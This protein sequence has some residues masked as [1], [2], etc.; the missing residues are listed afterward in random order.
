MSGPLT[1]VSWLK[2]VKPDTA[3]TIFRRTFEVA[4][5]TP[6]HLT[7]GALGMVEVWL[8]GQL[9]TQDRYVPVMSNYTWRDP[10]GR[11]YPIAEQP[12]HYRSYY[13]DYQVML[14][15][16]VNVLALRLGNGWYHQTVR[17]VEGPMDYG[18]PQLAY[19]LNWQDAQGIA[20]RLVSDAQTLC[21]QGEIRQNNLYSGEVHDYRLQPSAWL[22]GLADL[23]NWQPAVVVPAPKTELTK[24]TCPADRVERVIHPD[25]LQTNGNDKLFDCQENITGVVRVLLTGPAGSRVTLQYA[26]ELTADHQALDFASAGGLDQV[27]QDR[28]ISAGKPVVAWAHFAWHGFRYFSVDGPATV[29]GVD[30]IH[31]EAKQE[32]H[33]SSDHAGLNWLFASYRR[34]QLNN[35]HCGVPLDCPHRERLGYTGDGQLTVASAEW[36]FDLNAFYAKWYQDICDG[37]DRQTGHIQ[38]TAPYYG[39]GGGAGGWGA[40]VY[41]VP[42]T[43][44]QHTGDVAWLKRAWQPL[45]HWL[46]YMHAH[47]QAGLVTHEEEGG[48]NLGEWCAP[49][50]MTISPVFVNSYFYLQGLHRLKVIAEIL[51]QKVPPEFLQWQC[52]T[53]LAMKQEFQDPQTGSFCHGV[54]GADALAI[55]AGLGDAHTRQQLI[56]RYA[57]GRQLDTGIFATPVLIKT[58]FGLNQPDLAF[59]LAIGAQNP[60]FQQWQQAGAT[61]LWETFNGDASHDHVMFGALVAPLLAAIFGIRYRGGRRQL[62]APVRVQ[63][64]HHVHAEFPDLQVNYSFTDDF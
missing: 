26:E 61:T 43:L 38:H 12:T 5:K 14:Q 3:A 57:N 36:L 44:Y 7:I 47:S 33:F 55:D 51:Q 32:L 23:T 34:T 63:A 1:E 48:W 16:G 40:A 37:Q 20:Q 45:C 27:Q 6:A 22:S 11:L 53:K 10:A 19:C 2:A 52:E 28:F 9:V 35:L 50:P 21:S 8:N 49:D 31:T 25:C 56:A 29:A 4:A 58:L 62:V 30:V 54:N 41:V 46:V 64:L 15:T 18:T 60:W 42:W 13:L 24:Q 59:N 17:V 39:G